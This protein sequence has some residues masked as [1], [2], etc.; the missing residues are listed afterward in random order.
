MMSTELRNVMVE[1]GPTSEVIDVVVDERGLTV[2]PYGRME[3]TGL[4][5]ATEAGPAWCTI[6]IVTSAGAQALF[7]VPDDTFGG[8]L[9]PRGFAR[10][11]EGL[12]AREGARIVHPAGSVLT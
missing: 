11:L 9:S 12:A 10:W 4:E 3:W 7:F 5:V 1:L 2:G 6:R 8:G